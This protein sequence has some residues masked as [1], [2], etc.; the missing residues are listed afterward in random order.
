MA[1]IERVYLIVE[2]VDYNTHKPNFVDLRVILDDVDG[3]ETLANAINSEH[4]KLKKQ[5]PDCKIEELYA[6][7][8]DF[9]REH[10]VA[11][12]K[13]IEDNSVEVFASE[14]LNWEKEF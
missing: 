7:L 12:A 14:V 1:E 5:Y 10:P 8:P 13:Y 11:A 4:S 3:G 9:C 2:K 6:D